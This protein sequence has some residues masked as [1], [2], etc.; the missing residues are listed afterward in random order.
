MWRWQRR[1]AGK[2]RTKA[3]Q[4]AWHLVQAAT[5]SKLAD[6]LVS[7]PQTGGGL[8]VATGGGGGE[9]QRRWALVASNCGSH[10]PSCG[11]LS[12]ATW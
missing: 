10:V 8:Q 3:M 5:R 12:G 2:L 9:S 6:L 7:S 1:R 11:L 4:A